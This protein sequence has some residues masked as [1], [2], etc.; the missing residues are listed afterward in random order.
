MRATGLRCSYVP[1]WDPHPRSD[2]SAAEIGAEQAVRSG[3]VLVGWAKDV[4][5]HPRHGEGQLVPR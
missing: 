1:P 3:A 2:P 4:G 5:A